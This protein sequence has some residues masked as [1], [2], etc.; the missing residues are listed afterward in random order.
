MH[1]RQLKRSTRRAQQ[2]IRHGLQQLCAVG[3]T[4][5][6][7]APELLPL[8]ARLSK[9]HDGDGLALRT[10]SVHEAVGGEDL[11]RGAHYQQGV[12]GLYL[13]NPENVYLYIRQM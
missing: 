2:L 8:S 3:F 6:Y 13:L 9:V 7:N 5:V 4:L 12:A 11:Q 1:T 10:G